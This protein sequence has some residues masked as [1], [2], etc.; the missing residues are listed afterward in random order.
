MTSS[1]PIDLEGMEEHTRH[2]T[3]DVEFGTL[4]IINKHLGL[5]LKLFHTM[6]GNIDPEDETNRAQRF[7]GS[8][9]WNSL[10][11]AYH[12]L[13]IGYCT[14]AIILTRSAMEDW[15][16]L[17][18]GRSNP[19]TFQKLFDGERMPSFSVMADRLP[20][21][22]KVFWKDIDGHDGVYSLLSTISHPRYRALLLAVNPETSQL[23]VGPDYNAEHFI[24]VSHQTLFAISHHLIYLADVAAVDAFGL[25]EEIMQITGDGMTELRRQAAWVNETASDVQ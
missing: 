6:K 7:L 10:R 21:A 11:C 16:V 3:L 20:E 25:K 1:T 19:S 2:I 24:L 15:L 23:K 13:Q 14:Q 4:D 17:E 22:N 8:R 12:Q 5:Y 18:D 9:S